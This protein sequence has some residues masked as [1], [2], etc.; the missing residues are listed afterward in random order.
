MRVLVFEPQF[1]GHNLSYVMH[2]ITHLIAFDC[3][4]HLITSNQATESEEFANHLGHLEGTFQCHPLNDFVGRPGGRGICVNGPAG[5]FALLKGLYR[6]LRMVRPDHV[7]VPC[8][9]PIAHW[10]G[11]PNPVS[12]ELR[13]GSIEAEL[14]LLFGK[15]AYE[16]TGLRSRLKE[17]MALAVLSRGPWARIHH[18]VPRAVQV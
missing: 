7:Y 14:V 3:D 11:L 18:I 2:L 9:N 4:V 5:N 13:R 15:Y 12:R 8:G 16:H 17:W 6:G 1:A 10:A